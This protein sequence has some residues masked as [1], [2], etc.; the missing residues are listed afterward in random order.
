MELKGTIIKGRSV[1]IKVSLRN[2]TKTN[3]RKAS[4]SL[5][6]ELEYVPKKQKKEELTPIVEKPKSELSNDDFQN[7]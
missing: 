4:T 1:A 5:E 7:S 2:I 6:Q 3:K